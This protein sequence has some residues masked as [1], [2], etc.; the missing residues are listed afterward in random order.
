[1]FSRRKRPLYHRLLTGT[2]PLSPLPLHPRPARDEPR[3]VLMALSTHGTLLSRR[4]GR[5]GG[6]SPSVVFIKDVIIVITGR[7]GEGRVVAS[8]FVLTKCDD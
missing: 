7:Q 8:H 4:Y 2:H 5:Q 1:M 3:Y 6:V